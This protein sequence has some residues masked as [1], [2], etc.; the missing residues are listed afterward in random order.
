MRIILK[1]FMYLAVLGLLFSLILHISDLLGVIP[2]AYIRQLDQDY[3]YLNLG[4][5]VILGASVFAANH[6]GD[7][8]MP[9]KDFM[10]S[11][12]RGCPKWLKYL[13]WLLFAYFILFAIIAPHSRSMGIQINTVMAMPIYAISLV[14]LYSYFH[15]KVRKCPDGHQVPSA[16]KFCEEC[17]AQVLE[18]SVA[19]NK[20]ESV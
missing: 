1:L 6:A 19:D 15:F 18:L 9:E 17:G 4:M 10:K 16:A 14:L 11:Y 13:P 12:L 7:K 8:F 3:G 20:E 2:P 5:V